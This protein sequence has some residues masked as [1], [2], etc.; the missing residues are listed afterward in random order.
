MVC[1]SQG[2]N[3]ISLI[4]FR[5]VVTVL[6]LIPAA[7]IDIRTFIGLKKRLWRLMALAASSMVTTLLLFSSYKYISTGVSTG[8]HFLYPV[9]VALICFFVFRQPMTKAKVCCLIFCIIGLF[10]LL[11]KKE[12]LNPLGVSLAFLSS[13]IYSVYIVGLERVNL[14]ALSSIQLIFLLELCQLICGLAAAL[15]TG[16]FN[17]NVTAAGWTVLLIG[18]I[19]VSVFGQLFFIFGVRCAG[20]Q[21][22]SI[23]STSEPL[24]SVLI[25][26]FVL[27]ETFTASMIF[28]MILILL[29]VIVSALSDEKIA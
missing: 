9:F 29:A 23:I 22:A 11:D 18:E 27:K 26:A 24:A 3:Q 15:C 21:T 16:A 13:I 19:L 28:G 20:A 4:V 8:V 1:Y 17:M 14:N 10:L 12:T 5:S 6:M 2:L 25:G 7:R